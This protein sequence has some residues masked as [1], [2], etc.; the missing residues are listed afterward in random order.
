MKRL[1]IAIMTLLSFLV[2]ATCERSDMFNLAMYGVPPKT[3]IYLYQIGTSS[4]DAG[5]E[6]DSN[7]D[8]YTMG[9][10]YLTL[11]GAST[12]KAFRSFS[13]T[14][15]IRLLVPVQYWQYPV[16][17]ISPSMTLTTI[18]S[19]W[20]GL[21]DGAIDNPINTALGMT[22]TNYWWS[23]SNAD[24][25]TSYSCSEWNERVST[26]QGQAGGAAISEATATCDNSYYLVCLA[27]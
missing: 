18:S 23:G 11:A 20:A 22:L 2:F 3:A 9:L 26:E 27:Y 6:S 15:E 16:I 1:A 17:G 13:I 24:G 4:G 25:S 5:G 14:E 19:S 7:S 12:V 8:C 21:W 10:P